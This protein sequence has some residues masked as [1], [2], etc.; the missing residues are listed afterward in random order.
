M[1]TTTAPTTTSTTVAPTTTLPAKATVGA[2]SSDEAAAD[3]VAAWEH[4]DRVAASK[5]ADAEAVAG[6]FATPDPSMWIR[7]CTT[8]DTLPEG[9]C[10]YRT[11][12]GGI[13]I[14]TEKRAIGWVVATADYAP[15][16]PLG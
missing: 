14:N 16:A 3:L 4:H 1:L 7:G 12:H 11:D 10:I 5:V 6:I 2:A 8:D 15:I 9:G 13:T